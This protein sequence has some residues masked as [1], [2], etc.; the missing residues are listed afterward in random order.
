MRPKA[1]IRSRAPV[2]VVRTITISSLPTWSAA[3]KIETPEF[4]RAPERPLLMDVRHLRYTPNRGGAAQ[5]GEI[6]MPSKSKFTSI[7]Y[8]YVDGSNY[9]VH[10]ELFLSPALTP[11]QLEDIA[12]CLDDGEFFIPHDLACGVNE[13][14]TET[15]GFPSEDDHVWRI[16]YVD[17]AEV[18]KEVPKDAVCIKAQDLIDRLKACSG[19]WNETAA[20]ERLGLRAQTQPTAK[21]AI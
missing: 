6:Q 21:F 16:L 17:Q 20:M 13:L 18:V 7:P 19:Q 9:K 10:A 15:Q 3:G 8:A 14:Q 5:T 2:K 11:G 4:D 12:E 1:P